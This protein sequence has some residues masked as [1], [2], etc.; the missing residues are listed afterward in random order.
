MIAR[1]LVCR[2]TGCRCWIPTRS[3]SAA[4]WRRSCCAA[5][6]RTAATVVT[7]RLF[8]RGVPMGQRVQR[9]AAEVAA[10]CLCRVSGRRAVLR[11]RQVGSLDSILCSL[12]KRALQG[13]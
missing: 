11:R 4:G 10:G 9:P 12:C 6:L 5:F 2:A 3:P 8:W 7:E 1:S 13:G